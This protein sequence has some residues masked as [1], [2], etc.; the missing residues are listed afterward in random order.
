MPLLWQGWLR[1]NRIGGPWRAG[2]ASDVQVFRSLTR[3]ICC[4]LRR[5]RRILELVDPR[6][7]QTQETALA[8]V[9]QDFACDNPELEAWSLLYYRYVRIDL[10]LSV[11]RLSGLVSSTRRTLQ[12]RQQHGVARLTH[13]IIKHD[14]RAYRTLEQ[15]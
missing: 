11:E 5:Q 2:V 15:A 7:H 14:L 8:A 3:L 4:H 6:A 10:G 12:R 13:A 9:R 1:Q